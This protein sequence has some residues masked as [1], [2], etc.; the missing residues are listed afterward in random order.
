MEQNQEIAISDVES[1]A[2]VR[3]LSNAEEAQNRDAVSRVLDA[4]WGCCCGG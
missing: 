3:E 2:N 1:K 4:E